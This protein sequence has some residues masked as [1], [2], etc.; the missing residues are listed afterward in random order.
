MQKQRV[1]IQQHFLHAGVSPFWNGDT[2]WT[3][4]P[5]FCCQVGEFKGKV[6]AF[7]PLLIGSISRGMGVFV[8][9]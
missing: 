2:Q 3:H 7:L 9:D 4:R 6:Y 8:I 1:F 5:S